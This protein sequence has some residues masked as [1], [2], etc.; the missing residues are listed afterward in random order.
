MAQLFQTAGHPLALRRGLEED[1]GSRPIPQDGGEPFGG[2]ADALL[3]QIALG[4]Q[5][6]ELAFLLVHV[7]ANMVLTAVSTLWGSVFHHVEWG[8]ATSSDLHNVCG[9]VRQLKRDGSFRGCGETT[10]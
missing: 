10:V 8:S 7:D 2:G 1:A 9:E 4:A 6:A 3:D 5:D